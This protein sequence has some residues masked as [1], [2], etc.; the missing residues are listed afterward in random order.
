MGKGIMELG[1]WQIF[2]AYI[3]IVLVLFL[4]HR[5]GIRREKELVLA[6]VRMTLQ[7][8]LVGY[9]L[10]YIFANPAP[11]ITLVILAI[12]EVFAIFNIF[13]RTHMT[14]QPKL[15]HSV[16]VALGAN[17]LLGDL[18]AK[19]SLVEGALMLGATPQKAI[20]P[21][22][23]DAFDASLL[24]TINSML[25]MG[26][27]FLPGLMTGQ[28]LSG[29]SPLVAITYQIAVMLG[30][31]GSVALSVFVFLQLAPRA[32]F[33]RS[34]QLLQDKDPSKNALP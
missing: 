26:I 18:Q 8:I 4:A 21:L 15:Q 20:A 23:R 27:V 29:V 13:K 5:R 30:I 19:R 3:F 32:F 6:S 25:G 24:P 31:L 12:M 16:A 34:A 1:F 11:I 2:A 17:R 9:V 10:I 14:G 7:L 33:N 28:I 22:L